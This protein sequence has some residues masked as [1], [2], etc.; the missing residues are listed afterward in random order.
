MIF[1]TIFFDKFFD[2]YFDDFFDELFQQIF[3]CQIFWQILI[4][5]KIFSTITSFRIGVPSILLD[6]ILNSGHSE[7]HN[8]VATG[9]KSD[10]LHEA[11]L[12]ASCAKARGLKVTLGSL[13]FQS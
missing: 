7:S 5:W 12:A 9:T 3:F 8:I 4:F 2:D 1:L 11:A 13:C 10:D 6:I